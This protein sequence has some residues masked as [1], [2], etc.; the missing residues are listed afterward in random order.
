MCSIRSE[1]NNL[2][3]CLLD[4]PPSKQSCKGPIWVLGWAVWARAAH[5]QPIWA[6]CG[7]WS[8]QCGHGQP[9]SNPYGPHVGF[10]VG[11][12]S[13]GSPDPAHMGPMWV[14]EWAVWARAAQTQPIC[15]LL[16]ASPYGP[17]MGQPIWAPCGFL[18]GQCGHGQPRPNPYVACCGAARDGPKQTEVHGPHVGFRV[19]SVG[20]GSPDATHMWHAVGKPM[21]D[22]YLG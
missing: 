11:S 7:F 2:L 4:N 5:I 22:H 15:G 6:P 18:S 1:L 9:T 17:H 8:G 10:R 14:F 21:M 19:G 20:M 16:W 3:G 13:T 12:V